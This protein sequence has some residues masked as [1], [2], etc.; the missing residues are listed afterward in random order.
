VPIVT[1]TRA[2]ENA[3]SAT[4]AP[5]KSL[6]SYSAA[7]TYVTATGTSEAEPIYACAYAGGCSQTLCEDACGNNT[8]SFPLASGALVGLTYINALVNQYAALL[9]A[10]SGTCT[11]LTCATVCSPSSGSV[12]SV[13]AAAAVAATMIAVSMTQ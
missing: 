5:T 10:S 4:S 13:S 8:L 12:L 7:C 3:Q 11:P 2:D 1:C 9:S 6:S